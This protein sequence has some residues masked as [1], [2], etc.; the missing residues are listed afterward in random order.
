MYLSRWQS[1]LAEG[2]Q[3][4]SVAVGL[5]ELLDRC[6]VVRE[7][8]S[9]EQDVPWLTLYFSAAVWI[10]IALAHAPPLKPANRPTSSASAAPKGR[11]VGF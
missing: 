6:N 11:L 9:W 3:E 2:R 8:V 1:A 5:R 4:L 10:S 7:W